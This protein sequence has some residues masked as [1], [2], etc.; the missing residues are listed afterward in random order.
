[1]IELK[2]QREQGRTVRI[3]CEMAGH[4]DELLEELSAGMARAIMDIADDLPAV[5]EIHESLARVMG[6]R[7][8]DIVR[9]ELDLRQAARDKTPEA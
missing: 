4:T 7:V 6:S 8:I 2:M 9:Q 3:D 1:M 5:D